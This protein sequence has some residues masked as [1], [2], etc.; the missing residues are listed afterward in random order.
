MASAR[1]RRTIPYSPVNSTGRKVDG[2]LLQLMR[3]LVDIA[4]NT[5]SA[6]SGGPAQTDPAVGLDGSGPVSVPAGSP[7]SDGIH[8][9][10]CS[11]RASRLVEKHAPSEEL[12]QTSV[13]PPRAAGN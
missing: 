3:V 9:R 10:G 2:A 7:H 13:T 8:S 4:G 1:S 12:T 11:A 6:D 5:P